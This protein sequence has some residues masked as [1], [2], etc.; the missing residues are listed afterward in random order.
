MAAPIAVIGAANE[1]DIMN[2]PVFANA[3]F[4]QTPGPNAIAYLTKDLLNVPVVQKTLPTSHL[5][6]QFDLRTNRTTIA[7]RQADYKYVDYKAKNDVIGMY[8]RND[9]KT[10]FDDIPRQLVDLGPDDIAPPPVVVVAGA[11][12]V[13]PHVPIYQM[14]FDFRGQ[15]LDGTPF[16]N[17]FNIQEQFWRC[18]PQICTMNDPEAKP[19]WLHPLVTDLAETTMRRINATAVVSPLTLK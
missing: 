2:V 19:K 7:I 14:R 12:P 3:N 6:Y 13:A 10:L 4:A 16:P 1:C 11:A 5:E 8:Y 18:M 15:F 9:H 17:N